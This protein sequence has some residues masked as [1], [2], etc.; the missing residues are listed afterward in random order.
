M[1]RWWQSRTVWIGLITAVLG[2][3]NALTDGG[4]IHNPEVLSLIVAIAGL[5]Q[6]VLRMLTTT[7]IQ[8]SKSKD[9]PK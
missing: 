3:A 2:V 6:Y 7:A 1:K 4:L 9:K 5:L 8:T